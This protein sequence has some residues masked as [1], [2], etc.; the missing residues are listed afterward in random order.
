MAVVCCPVGRAGRTGRTGAR[1]SRSLVEGW[2]SSGQV[3]EDREEIHQAEE[4]REEIV[5][6]VEGDLGPQ[7]VPGREVGC[8]PA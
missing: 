5:G 4:G 1:T 2:S 7:A 6:Q 3:E 8:C